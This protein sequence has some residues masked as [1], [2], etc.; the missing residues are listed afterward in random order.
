MNEQMTWILTGAAGALAF[1]A[2]VRRFAHR[3]P[4]R[5]HA[6]ALV[7]AA[8]IYLAFA[9]AGGS[10]GGVGVELGGVAVFGGVAAVGLVRRMP[11]LLALGWA[12]H[13]LWDVALHTAG[14]GLRYTPA[15]YVPAC[16]GFDLA[17]A[18]LIALGWAGSRGR[19]RLP[20]RA[21]AW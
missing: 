18:A 9:A 4:S 19:D 11:W 6:M 15:G 14:E 1:G 13:P 12:L 21:D 20:S 16:I 5:R 10:A 8:L 3:D 2:L 17:L 7:V